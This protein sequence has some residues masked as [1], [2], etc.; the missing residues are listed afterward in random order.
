METGT[1]YEQYGSQTIFQMQKVKETIDNWE[2]QSAYDQ[3]V[4]GAK[5]LSANN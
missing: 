5:V 2:R 4:D 1:V 3:E